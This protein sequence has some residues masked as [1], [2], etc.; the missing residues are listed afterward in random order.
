MAQVVLVRHAMPVVEP[1][2]PPEQWRLGDDG[3]AAARRLAEALP[4]APFAVTSDEP[5]AKQ[6]AEEV[7]AV[8]GG[9]L[10]VD[11]RV[12]ETRRPHAWDPGFAE[13]ARQFVAGQRH[14]GW[15]SQAA[16]VSRFDAAVRDALGAS[17]GATVVVV[18]HGQALTLWLESVGAVTDAPRFW[19]ALRY[20]DAWTVTLERSRGALLAT[21]APARVP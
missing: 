19:S 5:K 4:R 18:D 3:R 12:G 15:E 16:V 21:S 8:C 7:V 1:T 2:V 6:T 20:P 14:D 9:S 17:R 11:A 10:T 13:L